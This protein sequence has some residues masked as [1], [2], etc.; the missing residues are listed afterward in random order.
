MSNR[1]A[2]WR[3]LSTLMLSSSQQQYYKHIR[4]PPSQCTYLHSNAELEQAAVAVKN[5]TLNETEALQHL[6]TANYLIWFRMLGNHQ[7][8]CMQ[9]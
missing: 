6:Y 1:L 9:D 5:L 7:A 2:Q 4:H 8:G 3:N